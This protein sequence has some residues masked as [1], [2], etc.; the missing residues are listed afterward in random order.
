MWILDI[1][2]CLSNSTCPEVCINTPGSY[3]CG[4]EEG[5]ELSEDGS[6]CRGI[7]KIILLDYFGD[8]NHFR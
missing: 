7:K 4:C 3:S 6:I 2:E 8:N 5:R 1:D